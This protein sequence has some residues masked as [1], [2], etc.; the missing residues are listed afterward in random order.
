M[1]IYLYLFFSLFFASCQIDPDDEN[2]RIEKIPAF[3]IQIPQGMTAGHENNISFKYPLLNGCY[4]FYGANVVD[5]SEAN[6]PDKNIREVTVF[7]E[8]ANEPFCTQ[9]YVEEKYY[10]AFRPMESKTYIFRFWTGQ[11][12]HGIDQFEEFEFVVE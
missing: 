8:I 1:R 10:L 6:Q 12:E 4:S 11:N 5:V 9:E 3:E 7:A 2:T